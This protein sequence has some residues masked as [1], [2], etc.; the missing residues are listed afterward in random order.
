MSS[1]RMFATICGGYYF[2]FYPNTTSFIWDSVDD[3]ISTHELPISYRQLFGMFGRSTCQK[4]T[5]LSMLCLLYTS[6]AAD[7]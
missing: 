4:V 3:M 1:L 7:D 5:D 2:D 6:D